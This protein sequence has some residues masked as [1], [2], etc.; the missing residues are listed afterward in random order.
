M[1]HLGYRFFFSFCFVSK[2]NRAGRLHLVNNHDNT[3]SRSAGEDWSATVATTGSK[4]SDGLRVRG[5][6]LPSPTGGCHRDG[7][8]P[9]PWKRRPERPR[10]SPVPSRSLSSF[11]PFAISL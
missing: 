1:A 7:R 4:D 11:P 5:Q 8:R 2:G 10:R 3:V 9:P 6:R